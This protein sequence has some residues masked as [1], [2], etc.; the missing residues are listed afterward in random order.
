MPLGYPLINGVRFDSSS[1]ELKVNLQRYI[2]VT[3]IQYEHGLNPGII[4]GL[5]PQALGF[6]RGIYDASGTLSLLREEF[7]DLT[8][9]LLTVAQGLFEANIICSVTYSELPPAAIP[10]GAVSGTTTDT[11]IGMRFTRSRHSIT[12]GSSD[13]LSVEMPF[14]ARYILVNGVLPL[15]QLLHGVAAATA[16]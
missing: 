13:G 9:N 6:T 10:T 16:P 4:R 2:G 15:N 8:P 12:G 7:N 5:N 14:I 1:V 3:S 11:I